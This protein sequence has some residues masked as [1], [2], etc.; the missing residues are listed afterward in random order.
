MSRKISRIDSIYC[1]NL[2][3]RP[4]RW[5]K[6][7]KQFYEHDIE[8]HRFSA[9][10]GS[11]LEGVPSYWSSVLGFNTSQIRVLELAVKEG[12]ETV[13]VLEDDAQLH[14]N[15]KTAVELGMRELPDDWRMCYLGGSNM[16]KPLKVS[17]HIAICK[18]TL[19][20]TGYIVRVNFAKQILLPSM[21]DQYQHKEVDAIFRDIQKSI[22]VHIFDPRIV[23]QY[24][25]FSDIQQKVVNYQHQRDF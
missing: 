13:M 23:Y 8:V 17:D 12:H 15:F 2:D 11:K 10:D 6:M 3:R 21:L 20:T 18:E 4:D 1:V 14:P 24:E 16:Q 5:E 7:T 19:A 25:D 9:T 22:D